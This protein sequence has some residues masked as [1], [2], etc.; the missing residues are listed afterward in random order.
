M[1]VLFGLTGVCGCSDEEVPV[2]PVVPESLPFPET[3]DKLMQNFQTIYESLDYDALANML[4]PDYV[5]ILQESTVNSFPTLGA[6][7]DVAEE[8]RIGERMFS[9]QDVLDPMG[10]LVPGIQTI[11]FQ[12]FARQGSWALSSAQDQIPNVQSALYEVV[13][14]FDRGQVNETLK[15]QGAIRFYVTPRDSVVAGVT[16]P[17]YRMIGQVDLTADQKSAAGG[18]SGVEPDSWGRVKA[19][20]R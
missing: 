15:V 9:R 18:S 20:F 4:H 14:L 2:T 19:I 3:P 16:K 5:T 17:Y 1:A 6:W 13:I 11:A 8:R 7:L 10:A 12:T